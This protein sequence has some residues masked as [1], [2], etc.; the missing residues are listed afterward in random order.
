MTQ[1][2]RL[3][4]AAESSATQLAANQVGPGLQPW[5]GAA[6]RPERRQPTRRRA[7]CSKVEK[8]LGNGGE[9]ERAELCQGGSPLFWLVFVDVCVSAQPEFQSYC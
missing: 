4:C 8:D 7:H 5:L 2:S 1:A 6:A 3:P 9:A